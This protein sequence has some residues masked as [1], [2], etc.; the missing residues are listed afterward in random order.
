ME[1]MECLKF[2]YKLANK[3]ISIDQELYLENVKKAHKNLLSL[4]ENN[5]TPIYGVDTGYGSNVI[6]KKN[7]QDWKDDQI[8]LLTYLKVGTGK[9]L[10]ESI[11]RRALRIQALK[12]AKGYSGTSPKVYKE[13]WKL[14]CQKELPKVPR[15]GSLGASGDL[16]PMAHAI[17]PIFKKIDPQG[18]RDVISLVNTN[19]MMASYAL[20]MYSQIQS[21]IKSFI[22]FVAQT[23]I[24]MDANMQHF[25][26]RGFKMNPQSEYKLVCQWINKERESFLNKH[27][28]QDKAELTCVQ[29]RYSLRCLPQVIGQICR[30]MKYVKELIEDEIKQVSDNPLILDENTA[31]HGGHFYAIGIATATDLMKDACTRIIEIIDRNVLNLMDP[32]ISKG[33]PTN[34]KIEKNDHLKGIHQLISSIL[35]RAKGL[36]FPS[37]LMSFSCEGNN[38]DIVPC[39][40]NALNQL[41]DLSELT[42][43]ALRA[44]LFCSERAALIRLQC[45]VP[46]KLRLEQWSNNV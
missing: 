36:N 16:I 23:T 3:D 35:Q 14:S 6:D 46:K 44:G 30:N 8:E 10:P 20:E 15:Y 33:L 22:D 5:K 42:S 17:A 21:I 13:L 18:P 2:Y 7:N 4:I 32:V 19:A 41:S 28:M 25:D 9:P 31:W 1:T 24:G 39:S 45:P 37:A 38:Q 11:V 27:F 26:I 29:E 43:D 34:L 40:M 12:V